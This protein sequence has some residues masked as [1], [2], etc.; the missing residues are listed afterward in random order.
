VLNT[1]LYKSAIL[2]RLGKLTRARRLENMDREMYSSLF[3][4]RCSR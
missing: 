2:S 1:A 4:G 3:P